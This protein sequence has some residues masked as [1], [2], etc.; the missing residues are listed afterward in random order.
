MACQWP[1]VAAHWQVTSVTDDGHA[2][3]P[4]RPAP[5]RQ[6]AR[7]IR[8]GRRRF[9]LTAKSKLTVALYD[10][11]FPRGGS[12]H[13]RNVMMLP[14]RSR[15]LAAAANRSPQVLDRGLSAK[16][17]PTG[18]THHVTAFEL[19]GKS[20]V[21]SDTVSPGTIRAAVVLDPRPGPDLRNWSS[22]CIRWSQLP[23]S[24]TA[25]LSRAV[26]RFLVVGSSPCLASFE[27]SFVSTRLPC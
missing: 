26:F 5:G 13:A 22:F 20:K 6:L 21:D 27:R 8:L 23:F 19:T 14:A 3:G 25:M 12:G 17:G 15:V 9:E 18:T 1:G 24:S 10:S 16:P 7:M 4:T 2:D 11:L